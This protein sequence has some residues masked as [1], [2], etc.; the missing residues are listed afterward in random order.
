[1]KKYYLS[2][3]QIAL[4]FFILVLFS[5]RSA[6]AQWVSEDSGMPGTKSLVDIFAANANAVWGVGSLQPNVVGSGSNDFCVTSNGGLN[7]TAGTIALANGYGMSNVYAF[8]ADTAWVSM[9]NASAGGGRIYYTSDG[10]INWTQKL[11]NAFIST[12]SFPDFITFK[13]RMTGCVVG[14]PVG[15]EFEIYRTTNG[16]TIWTLVTGANIVNPQNANEYG[17]TAVYC[18]VGSNIWF[19]TTTGRVYHSVDFG[20]H[21]TAAITG[22]SYIQSVSFKN[23]MDGLA[24]DTS[25]VM[26]ESHDGG[27]SWNSMT[28]VHSFSSFGIKYVPGTSNTYIA[29][30]R[31]ENHIEGSSYTT[32]G[33]LSWT[34]MDSMVYHYGITCLDNS[35]IWS[36]GYRDAAQATLFPGNYKFNGAPFLTS[37]TLTIAY[38]NG[39]DTM[40]TGQ[41]YLLTWQSNNVSNVDIFYTTDGGANWTSIVAGTSNNNS[42]NWAVPSSIA[43]S[44][45]CKI[46]IVDASNSA[47]YTASSSLFTI[48][49]VNGIGT[50]ENEVGLLTYPN[51]VGASVSIETGTKPVKQIYITDILGKK[52][53]VNDFKLT[54]GLLT[55]N[56]AKLTNGSYLVE[57]VGKDNSIRTARFVKE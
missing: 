57:I 35:N 16:G 14:D 46:K 7:W 41:S 10:G 21:W 19:G 39:G 9:Y 27:V 44:N 5:Q 53:I 6:T 31:D 43:T 29:V 56:T 54:E 11:S 51:P 28:P 17:I 33:G 48:I 1:M 30:G 42:Y 15:N 50:I 25:R 2:I 36:G 55:I 40:Y 34:T 47:L 26:Y 20:L 49:A 32:D 12:S 38:P 4:S 22:A 37:P 24:I 3:K 23:N 8:S 13:D 52:V 18:T 45:N